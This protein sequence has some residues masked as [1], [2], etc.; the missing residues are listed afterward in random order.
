MAYWLTTR[1]SSVY[2]QQLDLLGGFNPTYRKGT[3][4]CWQ[5]TGQG[6]FKWCS[7]NKSSGR[8]SANTSTKI[9]AIILN[10]YQSFTNTQEN[11]NAKKNIKKP[12]GSK[13]SK[14]SMVESLIISFCPAEIPPEIPTLP[15]QSRSVR[16]DFTSASIKFR[17]S[18]LMSTKSS[19]GKS[20]RFGIQ[21]HRTQWGILPGELR[22]H[23]TGGLNGK[24]I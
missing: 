12:V 19:V 20:S 5:A 10:H 18:N 15:N 2:P 16:A 11:H 1:H 6:F 13:V 4:I 22:S 3:Q 9:K 14:V 7:H 21:N 24:I 17:A 23:K 8:Q